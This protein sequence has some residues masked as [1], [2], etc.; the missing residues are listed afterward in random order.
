MA[1]TKVTKPS[2]TTYTK[3]DVTRRELFDSPN[4]SF[5]DTGTFFDG[6]DLSQYT[7]VSKPSIGFGAYTW[8]QMTIIWNN[9][10]K[11]WSTPYTKVAKPT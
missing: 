3:Q 6:T 7:D 11:D 10:D 4:I 1:Y 5:D 2:G 9:A 8:N